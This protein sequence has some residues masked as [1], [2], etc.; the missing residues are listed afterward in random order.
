MRPKKYLVTGGAG[1]I[2]SHLT[3]DLV[4]QGRDVV[5]LDNLST[6]SLD[7]LWAVRDKIEFIKAP[8]RQ[9]LNLGQLK[10]LDGIFHC[11][12]PSTT[13]LYRHNRFLV[14]EAV[15]DFIKIL[16]LAKS[17]KC[18][19]VYA[20]S[21]SLHNG[22]QP[23]FHEDMPI[24]IKDFYTEARYLIERLA[25]LYHDFYQVSQ[26]ALDCLVFMDLMKKQKLI[27]LIWF[28]SFYGQCK[29]ANNL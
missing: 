16:E 21:S 4:S 12:I 17:N 3:E 20:S 24:L 1:F 2:G 23:P 14:A 18:K 7:N 29:M 22:N 6:G 9:V 11:G 10:E 8:V 26:W 25:K 19:V 27:L 28:L 13:L 5:V 15:Q